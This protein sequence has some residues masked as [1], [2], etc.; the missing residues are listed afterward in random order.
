[1]EVNV[2]N[3]SNISIQLDTSP[4]RYYPGLKHMMNMIQILKKANWG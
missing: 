4:L 3:Q 1:M 2:E